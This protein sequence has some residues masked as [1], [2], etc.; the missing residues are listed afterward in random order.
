M[1]RYNANV[2]SIQQDLMAKMVAAMGAVSTKGPL[3]ATSI[4]EQ[5]LQQASGTKIPIKCFG[6]ANLPKYEE[7]AFHRW[8]DCPH[9]AEQEVW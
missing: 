8:Q 3:T 7:K 5:T 1:T 4:V 6:C 2:T 9:K